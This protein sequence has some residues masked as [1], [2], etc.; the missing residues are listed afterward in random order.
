MLRTTRKRWLSMR[1]KCDVL[2]EIRYIFYSISTFME[3][4]FFWWELSEFL[5][6]SCIDYKS[7]RF[8][9]SFF[10]RMKRAPQLFVMRFILHFW[11]FSGCFMCWFQLMYCIRRQHWCSTSW[12]SVC[13]FCNSYTAK[14]RVCLWMFAQSLRKTWI[15]FVMTFFKIF[16]ISVIMT[17]PLQ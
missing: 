15:Y 1:A 9:M 2:L 6:W 16:F 13:R 10:F 11:L 7:E 14:P 17:P 8:Y 3:K 5:M 12:G 4:N